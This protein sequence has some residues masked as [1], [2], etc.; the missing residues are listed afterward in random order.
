MEE[1]YTFQYTPATNRN[2]SPIPTLPDTPFKFLT[3]HQQ[4]E[5]LQLLPLQL[6]H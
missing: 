2:E 6:N 4:L 5:K 1:N 3:D